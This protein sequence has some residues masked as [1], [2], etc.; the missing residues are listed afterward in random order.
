M[1]PEK[2]RQANL[3]VGAGVVLQCAAAMLFQIKPGDLEDLTGLPVGVQGTVA[4]VLLLLSV[5]IFVRG[6]T[7]Y[8]AG[9]GYRPRVGAWGLLGVIGLIVL[10]LLPDRAAGQRRVGLG[11]IIAVILMAAGFALVLV[12]LW[13]DA[14][15][16]DV[17]IGRLLG[18]W[19]HVSMLAGFCLVLASL[20]FLTRRGSH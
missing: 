19:P 3:G 6:C 13:L 5:P 9:K 2:R 15:G 10:V 11:K 4:L 14:L 7:A 16:E 17:R 18:P 12:G 20:P 1:L 8:A